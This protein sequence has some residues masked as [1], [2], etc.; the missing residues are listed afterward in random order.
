M[1]C[2]RI[3]MVEEAKRHLAGLSHLTLDTAL[4]RV[5]KLKRRLPPPLS[6]SEEAFTALDR[7][8][9]SLRINTLGVD[10]ALERSP[11]DGKR[12]PVEIY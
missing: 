11:E 7:A 9:W 6:F 4:E 8:V 3:E 5:E 10:R 2:H 12:S 1:I